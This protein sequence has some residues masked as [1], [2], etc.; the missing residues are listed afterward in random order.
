MKLD[1]VYADQSMVTLVEKQAP[2]PVP[3]VQLYMHREDVEIRGYI[4]S[5]A[6]CPAVWVLKDDPHALMSEQWQYYQR[7]INMNM[8]LED[9]YLTLDDHL[10]FAN[11]TGYPTLDNPGTKADFFF[12]RNLTGK[13]PALDKVRTC[14]RSVLTGTEE[15]G[16][17]IVKTFDSRQNPPLKPGRTY[18]RRVE[19]VNPDDYLYLPQF[20]R[21]MF[22]VATIVNRR[23]EVVQFP[24]G[25]LYAWTNDNTPYTFLPHVSNHA[26]GPVRV[27]LSNLRKLPLGSPVPSPYRRE[28]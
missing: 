1:V 24:R 27:P 28:D 25:G 8:T 12:R 18:P 2:P 17:L 20:N 15:N 3:S 14:S 26:Y 11:W 13:P 6:P 10:A 5:C 4:R 23:G 16:Y 22:L 7:A 9:V 21:E 19:D